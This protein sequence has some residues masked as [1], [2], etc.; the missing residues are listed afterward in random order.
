M[1]LNSYEI[2]S[3]GREDTDFTFLSIY[4]GYGQNVNVS[5]ITMQLCSFS[6]S[7]R[8]DELAY[9]ARS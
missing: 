8:E 5:T 9:V 4:V 2:Y 3:I 7:V 6:N 1:L